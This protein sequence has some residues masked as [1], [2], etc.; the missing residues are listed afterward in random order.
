MKD[1]YTTALLDL[2]ATDTDFTS[3][4]AGFKDTLQKRGHSA[5]YGPVL[6]RVLRQLQATRPSTVLTVS[7]ESAREELARAI[8]VALTELGAP[9][10]VGPAVVVDDSIIGGFIAEH[11]HQRQN[12][13]YKSKLVS[14]Y[15]SITK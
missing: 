3:V 15:R 14:L 4:L 11:A 8:A 12:H 1:T 2:L 9:A 5:L 7:N 13:S 10:D 6:Q